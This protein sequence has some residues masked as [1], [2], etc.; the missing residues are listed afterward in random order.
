MELLQWRKRFW[1]CFFM[2]QC[3]R[4]FPLYKESEN[5]SPFEA[6]PSTFW[7][8]HELITSFDEVDETSVYLSDNTNSNPHCLSQDHNSSD[9][10]SL[11]IPTSS[12]AGYP[13]IDCLREGSDNMV[14]KHTK[15][16][17]LFASSRKRS[18]SMSDCNASNDD[19]HLYPVSPIPKRVKTKEKKGKENIVNNILL[20]H[21]CVT[22]EEKERIM[23]RLRKITV[24][25]SKGTKVDI[26]TML[27]EAVQYVKFLQ[28]QIKTYSQRWWRWTLFGDG[29]FSVSTLRGL[30][31]D[32]TIASVGSKTRWN[33]FVP[34]KI[35]ILAWRIKHDFLPTRYNISRRG[36]D[37]VS[38]ACASCTLAKTTSHIFFTCSLAN[39]LYLK[40]ARWW[41]VTITDMT[42]YE[43]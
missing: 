38:I 37:L 42:S 19:S 21:L 11:I 36:I 6:P 28:L 12:G 26:S 40:I 32:K 39:H 9:G 30:I 29:E 20:W 43:D 5:I 13:P 7:P 10:S 23:K 2:S 25:C 3:L 15:N 8:S 35:N 1:R 18:A 34:S 4:N 24:T 17:K 33:N 31:D 14:P 27:E 22:L 16:N 41:N